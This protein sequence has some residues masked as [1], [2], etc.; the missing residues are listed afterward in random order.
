M[1]VWLNVIL[2]LMSAAGVCAQGTAPE[3]RHAADASGPAWT[4]TPDA[5]VFF[6][7]NFQDRRFNNF[8]AWESQNWFM[9]AGRRPLGRG[10]LTVQGMISLEPFTM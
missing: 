4:W 9:L 7:F 6:G 10:R 1:R 2:V 5:N 8:T 3:Q